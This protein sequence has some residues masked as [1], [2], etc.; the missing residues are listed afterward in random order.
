MLKNMPTGFFLF[1]NLELKKAQKQASEANGP[2]ALEK[3]T[4]AAWTGIQDAIK[5]MHGEER[6]RRRRRTPRKSPTGA[7]PTTSSPAAC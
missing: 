3:G 1:P 4:A 5:G 2:N 7:M 6:R